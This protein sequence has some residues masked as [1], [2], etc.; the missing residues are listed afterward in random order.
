MRLFHGSDVEI[1]EPRILPVQRKLDFGNGFYTT[2][3]LPQATAW[4]RRTALRRR[5]GR[6]FVSV[7]EFDDRAMTGL[8]ILRFPSPDETWLQFVAGCR[9]NL[10]SSGD[11]DLIIG[12][13]AND[14][15]MPVLLLYLDG[16]YDEQ[17]TIRRLLPQK[18]KDQ[19]TFKTEA[20]LAFL[21]F[22]EVYE[23]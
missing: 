4:A 13:V 14:Q 3:D 8:N 20:A 7:Y 11:W 19:Y 2:S 15:T 18:L 22:V 10:V 17:E 12:P 9:R 21:R 6:A 16:V 5:S 1:P 23:V